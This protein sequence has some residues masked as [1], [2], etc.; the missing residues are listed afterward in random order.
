MSA[1]KT[2]NYAEPS[3]DVQQRLHQTNGERPASCGLAMTITPELE[4][5]MRRLCEMIELHPE[6]KH[7]SQPERMENFLRAVQQL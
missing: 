4:S 5:F 3:V 6:W 1:S 7:Q 2:H